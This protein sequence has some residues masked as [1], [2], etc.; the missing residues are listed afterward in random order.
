MSLLD[1]GQIIKKI[2]DD[3]TASISVTIQNPGGLVFGY[4]DNEV[5]EPTD[6]GAK[7]MAV[8]NDSGTPLASDG[9]FI[10]LTTDATGSLR[11][12]A[13]IAEEA[14]GE[15]G[16][17]NPSKAKLVAGSD[18][19]NLQV[20]KTDTNGVLSVD[21]TGSTVALDSATI[22]AITAAS[23]DVSLLAK[24]ATLVTLSDKVPADLTVS[25]NKLLVDGSGVTQPV[26][27]DSLPLPTGAATET[28]LAAVKAA[29]E[30]IDNAISGNEMQVDVKTLEGVIDSNNSYSGTLDPGAIFTGNWTEIKDYNSINLGVHSDANSATDGLRIRYSADGVSV[31][32]EHVWTFSASSNGV[33]YQLAAEFRYFSVQYTNGASPANLVIVANLKP[34]S[35]SPSSYRA[36]RPFT[37]ESQVILTKGIIS[38][39]T[40]AGGGGFV[41]VKVNPSGA[42]AVQAEVTS[43]TLPTGASTEAKQDTANLHLF[44]IDSKLP[45]LSASFGALLVDGSNVTQPVSATALDI[46]DLDF[47]TDKVDATGSTVALDAATLAALENVT[48]DTAGLATDAKQ[49]TGNASLASIDGKLPSDLT[50]SSTRLLVDG[51]GVT[52]PVSATDLDVRDLAFATDKVDVTGSTVAL[53]GPTLAALENINVTVDPSGL[54]SETTVASIDGKLPSGLTVSTDK[55]LVDGSG[56]TQPV[57][58][59]D[60][61]IRDLSFST[62]KVDVSGSVVAL[63]AASLAALEDITVVVSNEVEISNDASNPLPVSGTVALDAATLAALENINVTV[64]PSGLAS[65]ATLSSLNGKVTAVDTG[66]VTVVS[67]ALPSGAATETTL[68]AIKT[69]VELLDDAVSGSELQVDVVASLPAGSNTIGKVDVNSLSVVDLLDA[70]ILD[71]SSTNIPGSVSAAL[72]VV[73]SLASNVKK[74]QILDTTGAFIGL[75]VA[76]AL[77]LV[78]GPGSDQTIE[79]SI[80]SG[81]TI[82]LKRLD[83]TAAID[84]GIVAINFLG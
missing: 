40:T 23:P 51:S 14:I 7:M 17:P 16:Q 84:S 72:T 32:H 15:E 9:R 37:S 31:H 76:D 50:V 75:Y 63:D 11:V 26:S 36:S 18:G 10:P 48:I 66:N 29:V 60:L 30:I 62:D 33:G 42:L 22:N 73:S 39:V 47:A 79:H 3:A 4:V 58:A 13:T 52:Q 6:T 44:S 53:D 45:N 8:R 83:G 21:S 28:S 59:T 80:A 69:A 41:D 64:D 77:A 43:S 78:I 25:S 74:M 57:S 82:K 49:D 70:N 27:A 24:D 38:G 55:L 61:D 34:T 46:R 67:S 56:V 1:P 81:S 19:T 12:S 71:T 35:L 68:G 5:A 20:L 54:A 65:E 2:Y